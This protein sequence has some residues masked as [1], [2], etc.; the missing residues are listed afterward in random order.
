MLQTPRDVLEKRMHKYVFGVNLITTGLGND[1][2]Y[3]G[4]SGDFIDGGAGNNVIF[5]GEGNNRILTGKGN[6]TIYA[7]AGNDTIYSGKGVQSTQL[8]LTTSDKLP[9]ALTQAQPSP[10]QT[11]LRV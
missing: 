2:I 11:P 10:I 9:D 1:V 6:D 4:A 3:C 8:R 7:G 5:A